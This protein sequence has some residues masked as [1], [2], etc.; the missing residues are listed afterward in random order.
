VIPL[1][2][3]RPGQ[4]IPLADQWIVVTCAWQ[5]GPGLDA[6]LSALMLDGGR[7]VRGDS[8]FVFY[9]QPASGDNSVSHAG[10]RLLGDRVQDRV[11]INMTQVA[12]DVRIVAVVVSV[13]GDPGVAVASL[14]HL[15][16]VLSSA[17]GQPIAAFAMPT[18]TT[19]TA[20]VTV[21]VYRRGN[22]WKARA[23]GQGYHDGLAGLARD[24][25]VN[26]DDDPTAPRAEAEPIGAP[27][28][29]WTNPPVPA[30]YEL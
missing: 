5:S 1:Q 17:G 26:V 10:K 16:V 22:E 13:D 18:L 28:I 2:F 3:L 4:N 14:P 25:G 27:V 8:D 12:A 30:G 11:D 19:E 7:R 6:D 29:D 24:F 23:I 15:E 21:E 9:N 20:V